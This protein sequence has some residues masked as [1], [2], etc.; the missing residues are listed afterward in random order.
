MSYMLTWKP[1]AEQAL[2]QIWLNAPDRAEITVASHKIETTLRRD[3]LHAG[4]SRRE[5]FRVLIVPPLAV[6]FD[7]EEDDR[8]VFVWR[9]WRWES[10]RPK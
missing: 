6:Y 8:R 9:L 3:P 5:G 7:V 2:A 10:P 1:P 4:E